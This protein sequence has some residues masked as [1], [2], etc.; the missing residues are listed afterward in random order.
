MQQPEVGVKQSRQNSKEG[1]GVKALKVG[2]CPHWLLGL[3][4][5]LWQDAPP[6]HLYAMNDILEFKLPNLLIKALHCY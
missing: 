2:S 6:H 5:K 1:L 4:L 3:E